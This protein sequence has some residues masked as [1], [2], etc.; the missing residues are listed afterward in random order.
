MTA[1]CRAPSSQTLVARP[2]GA[3]PGALAWAGGGPARLGAPGRGAQAH[4]LVVGLE[5]AGG[6]PGALGVEALGHA[7]DAG[8]GELVGRP[9]DAQALA[10]PATAR[11]DRAG[12]LLGIRPSAVGVPMARSRGSS[13]IRATSAPEVR[14]MRET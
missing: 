6:E 4:D 2:S 13:S 9:V 3:S 7:L 1:S 5:R 11:V 10:L 8:A 14:E 12:G